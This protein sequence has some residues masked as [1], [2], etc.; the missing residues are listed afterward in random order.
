MT[1]SP[2]AHGG[3]GPL[4]PVTG[5]AWVFGPGGGNLAGA[6]LGVAEASAL[7]TTVDA[8]SAFRLDV[9]S[10][11]DCSFVLKQPGFHDSQTALLHV[12]ASGIE[13]VSF[14]MP[15]DKVFMLMANLVNLAPDPTRCQIA[16]TVSAAGTAPYGGDGLGV[17]E[18]TVSIDPPLLPENGPVYFKYV[19]AGLIVPDP[20]LTATTIDGGV[21]FLNVPTGDYVLSARRP[22]K[23][24]TSVKL[25]CRAGSLVNA[26]PP[27]GL[28]EIGM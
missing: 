25:R 14:Q 21:L 24:F 8:N 17:P 6:S 9:P 27:W 3:S 11:G 26:A 13:Q 28:Q 4:V 2:P 10:G 18:A 16:T 20:N 1:A 7:G 15:T 5:M 19:R 12:G 22:G 23:R